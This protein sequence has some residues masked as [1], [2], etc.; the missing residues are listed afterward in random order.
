MTFVNFKIMFSHFHKS[1]IL[2][3]FFQSVY[4]PPPKTQI[5]IGPARGCLPLVTLTS[6]LSAAVRW[7][8]S[9]LLPLGFSLF[10]V[11]LLCL[12]S[13][14]TMG[15]TLAGSLDLHCQKQASQS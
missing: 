4:I 6:L 2:T 12:I 11:F 7:Y 8:H 10:S 1:K 9:H 13:L 15:Q 14:R 5:S 3:K